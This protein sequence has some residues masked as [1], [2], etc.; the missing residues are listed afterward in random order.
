MDAQRLFSDADL[1]RIRAATAVAERRTSGEIVA[2]VV[3]RCDDYPELPWVGA[4]LGA[5]A[6]AALAATAHALGGLWGAAGLWLW[7]PAFAGAAVGSQLVARVPA[8]A[9]ALVPPATLA[10]RAQAR[11]EAAFLEEEV[12]KTRERTGILIFLALFEHRAIVLG[13]AGINAAVAQDAWQSIVDDLVAGIRA[14]RPAEALTEA[15]AACGAL[16]DAHRVVRRPDDADELPDAP[17]IR[18]R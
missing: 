10:L 17:R 13:D 3:G 16:L 11:A 5:L 14:G 2:Y 8:V 1:N 6:G 18:D 7:L 15:V 9:R 4:A 12:F